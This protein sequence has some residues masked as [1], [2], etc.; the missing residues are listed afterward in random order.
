MEM[1]APPNLPVAVAVSVSRPIMNIPE[2]LSV[3]KATK[4]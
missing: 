3:A 4:I 2:N 1:K